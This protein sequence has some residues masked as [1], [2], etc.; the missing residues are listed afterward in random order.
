[1]SKPS[2][3]D[4]PPHVYAVLLDYW[5]RRTAARWVMTNNQHPISPL[6]RLCAQLAAARAAVEQLR[7]EQVRANV[8]VSSP[9]KIDELKAELALRFL[10]MW[11]QPQP[12]ESDPDEE[13]LQLIDRWLNTK[14]WDH[15]V[16]YAKLDVDGAT[17]FADLFLDDAS[18]LLT[19][20]VALK[21]AEE[22]ARQ[23]LPQMAREGAG[24]DSA[25]DLATAWLIKEW[26]ERFPTVSRKSM[27]R[28]L[29]QLKLE[30]GTPDKI[31]DRL[32]KAEGRRRQGA[33][34][35]R[36]RQPLPAASTGRKSKPS[37]PASTG[38]QREAHAPSSGGR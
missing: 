11:I 13:G 4:V 28:W 14:V 18:K 2:S 34:T 26:R 27:A 33:T 24:N 12:T 37:P 36:K 29:H 22:Q 1:M 32:R 38:R 9:G 17:T 23:I 15:I 8:G 31:E 10:E 35:G 16:R 25:R 30:P 6:D 20:A 7:D 3:R 19:V 5:T 21:D